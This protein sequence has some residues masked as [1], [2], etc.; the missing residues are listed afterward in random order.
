MAI[1]TKKA[2]TKTVTVAPSAYEGQKEDRKSLA[3]WSMPLAQKRLNLAGT[4]YEG[5][6]TAGLSD[7]EQQGLSDLDKY[8][9]SPNV[10]DSRLY[11]L[12]ENELDKTLS[13][14]EY[15]PIGGTYY[16][17]YRNQV[18][19]ELQNAKDRLNAS[20]SARDSFFGGGRIAETGNLERG[21][22]NDLSLA[23]GQ[24]FENERTRRLG[25]VPTA[26]SFMQFGEQLPLQRIAASQ[27]YG[28][29]PREIEQ[30]GLMAD[31]NEWQRQLNDLGIGLDTALQ[32]ATLQPAFTSQTWRTNVNPQTG[33]PLPKDWVTDMAGIISMAGAVGMLS[34]IRAKEN[35]KTIDNA[36]D[37]IEQLDG[38]TYK[39]KTV[40]EQTAGLIAQDV[41][42][43]LPQAVIEK[44][45][46]KY[47]KYEA[48][49]ALLVNA[50]KEL[51]KQLD[52]RN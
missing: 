18:M 9:K 17:A 46:L 20:T 25:A 33:E 40:E 26:Q 1:F 47:I 34:D 45:G 49:I 6:L 43:V 7:Y 41:E 24:L 38:K 32:L 12:A 13:G 8:L 22:V 31:Y 2:G 5:E 37:K 52:K 35:V 50:V 27:Q 19:E 39:Y 16:Q 15:D 4:P 11:G 3:T 21:A 48:V 29:L 36:L 14:A 42:N 23:L 30:A 10:A 28:A 51:K 44:D